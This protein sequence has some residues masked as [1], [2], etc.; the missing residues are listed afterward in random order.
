MLVMTQGPIYTLDDNGNVIARTNGPEGWTYSNWRILGFLRRHNS[1]TMVSLAD[2]LNGADI[3]HGYVV[4]CDHGTRRVW[5]G[6][7]GRCKRLWM[8]AP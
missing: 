7:P 5:M 3:G 1:G 2:A 4:D 6:S 8:L